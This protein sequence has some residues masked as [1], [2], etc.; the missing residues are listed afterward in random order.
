M[1][2][3]KRTGWH[4]YLVRTSP[5]GYYEETLVCADGSVTSEQVAQHYSKDEVLGV[6]IVLSHQHPNAGDAILSLLV[7]R[8]LLPRLLREVYGC[9]C[10]PY[11]QR[12]SDVGRLA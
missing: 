6:W 7:L 4:E 8:T 9:E 11:P 12:A 10:A 3:K 2:S 1:S 5:E